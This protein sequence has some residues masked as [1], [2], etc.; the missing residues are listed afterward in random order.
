MHL[1][2]VTVKTQVQYKSN[3]EKKNQTLNERGTKKKNR[4]S[5][6]NEEIKVHKKEEGSTEMKQGEAQ[7]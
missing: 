6:G 3:E 1:H 4:K 2:C 7:K 5:L